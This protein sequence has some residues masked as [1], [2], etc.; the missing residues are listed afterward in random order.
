LQRLK[1][2]KSTPDNPSG[3]SRH[4]GHKVKLREREK[5]RKREKEKEKKEEEKLTHTRQ[6][7]NRMLLPWL[8]PFPSQGPHTVE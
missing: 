6:R 4:N 5:K 8:Y 3:L 1:L 7:M 2:S